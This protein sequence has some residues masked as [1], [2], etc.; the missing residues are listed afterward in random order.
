M[1]TVK[2][3]A[4]IYLRVT[5]DRR[6]R[7]CNTLNNLSNKVCIPNKSVFNMI[8]RINESRTLVKHVS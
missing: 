3:F 7:S 8:T 5:L 2:N 1:N 6:V 4:S